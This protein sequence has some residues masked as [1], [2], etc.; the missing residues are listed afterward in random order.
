MKEIG[1]RWVRMQT[2]VGD[3]TPFGGRHLSV[4]WEDG[5][6]TLSRH[7]DALRALP[8]HQGIRPTRGSEAWDKLGLLSL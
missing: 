6:G 4:L 7:A 1:P 3:T 8:G 5:H 2:T